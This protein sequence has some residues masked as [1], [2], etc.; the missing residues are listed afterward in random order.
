MSATTSTPATPTAQLSNV[1]KTP[2]IIKY[3]RLALALI[4]GTTLFNV[5]AALVVVGG[6]NWGLTTGFQGTSGIDWGAFW[7]AGGPLLLSVIGLVV[8]VAAS[9]IHHRL[10]TTNRNAA[11]TAMFAI[12]LVVVL[13]I[14]GLAFWQMFTASTIGLVVVSLVIFIGFTLL[15][16]LAILGLV[17]LLREK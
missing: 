3:G 17:R 5:L 6:V 13:I 1:P 15:E 16:V 8:F 2:L 4:I 9:F 10:A 7:A 11:A 14:G 12:G